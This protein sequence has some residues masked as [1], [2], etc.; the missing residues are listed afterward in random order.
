MTEY[1]YMLLLCHIEDMWH[2]KMQ[3]LIGYFGSA[4][5]IFNTNDEILNNAISS[6]YKKTKTDKEIIKETNRIIDAK[7]NI[8]KIESITKV[9]QKKDIKFTYY[10]HKDFPD[11]LRNISEPP[12]VLFYRGDLPEDKK[13]SVGIVG[14]RACTEYGKGV[15]RRIASEVSSVGINVI[16]GMARGIDSMAHMGCLD[17]RC[18]TFAVVGCGVDICYPSENIELYEKIRNNGGIISEYPIGSEPL[19]YRF[20]LRNRIISGLS[21][22]VVMIEAKERSG[23]FITIDHA[24]T[25]GRSVYALPGR[26]TDPLSIGCNKLILEGATPLINSR[27]IVEELL[28]DVDIKN[29]KNNILLEKEFEVLYSCLDLQPISVEELSIKLEMP[30]AEIYEKLLY[31]E[32]NG[33]AY[34]SSKGQYSKK[35]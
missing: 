19:A 11:R 7:K 26:V 33:L 5:E 30:I 4:K 17:S 35:F 6:I 20:P 18:K 15:A 12:M 34:E 3:K 16:S 2:I 1:E 25:Q 23:S 28:P 31:L 10:G 32:L 29:K 13:K 8:E 27:Q 14:A 24:L 21:D 22:A 9:M